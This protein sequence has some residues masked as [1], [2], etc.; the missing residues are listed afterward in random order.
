MGNREEYI[1]LLLDRVRFHE[2]DNTRDGTT[3]NEEAENKN[4]RVILA[5]R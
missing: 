4:I 1:H 3:V 5:T 2:V